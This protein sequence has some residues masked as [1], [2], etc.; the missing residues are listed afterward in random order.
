MK[1]IETATDQEL[2]DRTI[3]EKLELAFDLGYIAAKQKK[4]VVANPYIA[5]ERFEEND[6][7]AREAYELNLKL[8]SNWKKGFEA[9]KSK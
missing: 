3:K 8:S 1:K 9:F 6:E 4:A 2:Y 5:D 7:E